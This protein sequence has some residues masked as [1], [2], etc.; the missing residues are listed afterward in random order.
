MKKKCDREKLVFLV[1]RYEKKKRSDIPNS[2][3]KKKCDREK[4]VGMS[5]RFFS[6]LG[7]GILTFHDC[8]SC[9]FW[10]SVYP[11]VFLISGPR[12]TNFSRVF[13]VP[14]YEKKK[15]SDIPNSKIKKKCDR[16]K[17]VSL[18]LD[19]RKKRS[20]ILNSKINK[21]CDRKKLVFLVF[22][23][24]GPRNTNFSRSHFLFILE[25]GMSDSYFSYLGQGI[26][27]F[28]DRISCLFWSSV[29]IYRT[30]K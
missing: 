3:I 7:Q 1:P 16:E 23:I 25:F 17:L 10:S 19:M 18:V 28:L 30:P 5:E 24:S 9:L 4:L 2:K 11:T 21:K 22:L 20:D 12:N 15:R 6:Y 27:T 29:C 13:L 14:R 26:L 8:I